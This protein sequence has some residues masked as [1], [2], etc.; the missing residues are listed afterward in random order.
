MEGFRGKNGDTCGGGFL[1]AYHDG[2]RVIWRFQLGV[3]LDVFPINTPFGRF[4]PKDTLQ[5]A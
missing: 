5:R 4:L 2:F 3:I 1:E